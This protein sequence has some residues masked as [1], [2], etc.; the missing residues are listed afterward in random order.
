MRYSTF[1]WAGACVLGGVS[2]VACGQGGTPDATYSDA[3]APA[4]AGARDAPVNVPDGDGA[5]GVDAATDS[6]G[7]GPSGD[8]IT[9]PPD[10]PPGDATVTDALDDTGTT[11]AGNVDNPCAA[12]AVINLNTAG[13]HSGATTDYSGNTTGVPTTSGIAGGC[14]NDVVSEIAFSY[15]LTSSAHLD[16]STVNAGTPTTF[17]TFLWVLPQC[18]ASATAVACGVLPVAGEYRSEVTTQVA[19]AAGVTVYVLVAGENPPESGYTSAGPFELTVTEVPNVA[20]GGACDP[21]GMANLCDQGSH[22]LTSGG[23]SN[24][25]QDGTLNGACTGAPPHCAS[26][27]Q[28]N[29]DPLGTGSSCVPVVGMGGACDPNRQDPMNVCAAPFNCLGND[30]GGSSCQ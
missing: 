4:D 12:G 28:C 7:D 5:P 23:S 6:S 10:A 8:A 24:C 26:G 18:S 16:V 19:F 9:N 13:G 3:V 27:L 21:T 1:A 22:C 29:G 11:D 2:L 14:Q 30:A 20:S 25:V 15:T 17:N